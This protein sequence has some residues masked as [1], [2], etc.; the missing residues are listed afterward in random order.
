MIFLTKKKTLSHNPIWQH[1]RDLRKRHDQDKTH[2]L[3]DDKKYDRP[4]DIQER[5]LFWDNAFEVKYVPTERRRQIG[6]FHIHD[7]QNSEPNRVEAQQGYN[8]DINR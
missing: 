3:Q 1:K 2:Q 8:G 7:K 6:N 4:I 5:N